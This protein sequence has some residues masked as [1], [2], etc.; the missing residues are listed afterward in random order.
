MGRRRYSC[1]GSRVRVSSTR[2]NSTSSSSSGDG[3]TKVNIGKTCCRDV[4]REERTAPRVPQLRDLRRW[5][6]RPF[7]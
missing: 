5:R 1:S 6:E 2:S 7:G 3:N 4:E